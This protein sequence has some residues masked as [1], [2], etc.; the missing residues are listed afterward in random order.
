MTWHASRATWYKG[1]LRATLQR[2]LLRVAKALATIPPAPA[3][4]CPA[5]MPAHHQGSKRRPGSLQ[6]TGAVL[7]QAQGLGW[8]QDP[9]RPLCC[10]TGSTGTQLQAQQQHLQHRGRQA[11]CLPQHL[12]ATAA[13]HLV[14]DCQECRAMCMAASQSIPAA[15]TAAGCKAPTAMQGSL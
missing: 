3:P 11:R 6:D 7:A 14:Q 15:I 4:K 8:H 1:T 12:L 5:H 10:Q 2:Y 9:P 13:G